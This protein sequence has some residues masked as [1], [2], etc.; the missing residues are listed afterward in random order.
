MAG[1]GLREFE[2]ERRIVGSHSQLCL[3]LVHHIVV[4]A[5]AVQGT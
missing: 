2:A 3:D 1:M 4:G 5:M